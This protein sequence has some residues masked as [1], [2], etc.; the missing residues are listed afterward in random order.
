MV[1]CWLFGLLVVGCCFLVV[2]WS[3]LLFVCCLLL[4]CYLLIV[5]CVWLFVDCGFGC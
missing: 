2:E 1:G 5:G 4:V 3:L